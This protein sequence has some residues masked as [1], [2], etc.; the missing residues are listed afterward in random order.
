MA[1]DTT[2]PKTEMIDPALLEG[3]G[4]NFIVKEPSGAVKTFPMRQDRFLIGRSD[5]CD[6]PI[7][8]SSVSGRHAEISRTD[9]DIK[10][11]DVGSANG[12]YLNGERVEEAE[13]FDGDVLRLGQT[14]IRI[15]VVGGRARATGGL[16]LRTVALAVAAILVLGTVGAGVG[17]AVRKKQQQR[18]DMRTLA[19]FVTAAREGQRAKPCAAI[20]DKV[21]DVAKALAV[22]KTPY[23]LKFFELI[24]SPQG[25]W[26]QMLQ[27]VYYT[28]DDL[29]QVIADARSQMIAIACG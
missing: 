10:I 19:A 21:Q 28:N 15:D 20:V 9:G 5:H 23:T 11:R 16:P 1:V 3:I 24:N 18:R 14:S 22:G 12:I 7:A 6:L 2:S 17:I 13:L 8:D 4:A 25:P 29:D 26:L 27:R